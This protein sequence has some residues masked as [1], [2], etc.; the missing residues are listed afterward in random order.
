MESAAEL[1]KLERYVIIHA[2]DDHWQNHLTEMDELR[3]SV[4]LRGYGQKDP[5]NEYKN[6]A[7]AF[8]QEMIANIRGSICTGLFRSAT[9]LENFQHMLS[10]LSSRV[11]ASG[12][13]NPAPAQASSQQKLPQ[14]TIQREEPRIGRNDPCPCGSG[15]K[16]KKCCG[17]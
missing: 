1:T 3:R 11:N 8:F 17:K 5:L 10:R 4:G 6:D 13:S 2:I 12:P 9:N 15:K 14:V 7:Y 16:Y